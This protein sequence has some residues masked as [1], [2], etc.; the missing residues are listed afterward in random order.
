MTAKPSITQQIA[1]AW[2]GHDVLAGLK[3]PSAKERAYAAPHAEAA[4]RTLEWLKENE[5]GV[6]KGKEALALLRRWLP[7]LPEGMRAEVAALLRDD[8]GAR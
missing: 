2:L 8:G 5:N 4:A 3:S 6:R 7:E 1:A